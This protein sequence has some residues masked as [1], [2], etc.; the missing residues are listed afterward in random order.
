[1][2][3][4]PHKISSN[5]RNIQIRISGFSASETR[6]VCYPFSVLKNKNKKL[7]SP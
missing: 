1:M 5:E 3:E 6:I 2:R 7:F 4:I